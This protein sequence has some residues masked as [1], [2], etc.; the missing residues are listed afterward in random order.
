MVTNPLSFSRRVH[1]DVSGLDCLPETAGAVLRAGEEAGRKSIV[2]EVPP[3]GFVCVAAGS[4][5]TPVKPAPRRFGLFRKRRPGHPVRAPGRLPM[6]ELA[7]CPAAPCCATSSSNWP[8][9]PIRARSARSSTSTPARPR[10][11]Q[12]VAMRLPRRSGRRGGRLLDHGGRRDPRAGR[13][14]GGG[15]GPG[16]RT[17]GRS[18][19]STPGRFSAND[20][21]HLG[22]PRDRGGNRTRSPAAN[23]TPTRGIRIMRLDS[24]GGRIRRPFIAA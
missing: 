18:S 5:Q 23:R 22:Q 15:R 6:A 14:P 2:V 21:H 3:L 7:A 19:R 16:P 9:I 4:G 11:A 13:R 10:L 20:P 24:P 17:A 8:S 12:Q 1:V